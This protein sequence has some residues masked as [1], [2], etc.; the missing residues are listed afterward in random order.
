MKGGHSPL[1]VRDVCLCFSLGA[2]EF[3]GTRYVRHSVHQ[4]GF[5]SPTLPVSTPH[6][7]AQTLA[8]FAKRTLQQEKSNLRRQLSTAASILSS[9]AP[10]AEYTPMC[11]SAVQ[12][13]FIPVVLTFCRYVKHWALC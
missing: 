5:R 13:T 11:K 1:P 8:K 4:K 7:P 6:H 3:G 9:F 12:A 2:S 10:Q